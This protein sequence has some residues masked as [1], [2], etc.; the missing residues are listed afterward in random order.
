MEVEAEFL[1]AEWYKEVF[2]QVRKQYGSVVQDED[3]TNETNNRIRKNFL[4]QW[5]IPLLE[6]LP[7]PDIHWYIASVDKDDFGEFLIIRET[8]WEKTFGP[9]K[10]LKDVAS[11]I[12]NGIKD[13]GVGFDLIEKI[14]G[15]IGNHPF[16]ERLIL[17]ASSENGPFTLVE[18]NHRGVAF[19]TKVHE[20]GNS[21]HLPTEVI[22]GISPNMNISPWLNG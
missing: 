6:K 21:S 10:K 9:S 4:W 22:I 7:F 3:Y 15:N 14:K 2:D 13:Q 16:R 18:G 1:R 12:K 5:R 11:A 19:Q 20:N 8:G 17:I